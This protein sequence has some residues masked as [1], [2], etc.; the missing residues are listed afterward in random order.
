MPIRALKWKTPY[1]IIFGKTLL[2]AYLAPI[3]CKAYVLNKKLKI[4]DKLE[5]R[6]FISYLLRYNST[7]IYRI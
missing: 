3:R 6:T 4:V 1:E 5:S 7:N 2:L